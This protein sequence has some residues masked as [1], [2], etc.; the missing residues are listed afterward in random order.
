MRHRSWEVVEVVH[1]CVCVLDGGGGGGW[2]LQIHVL[3][4]IHRLC[5]LAFKFLYHDTLVLFLP[6]NQTQHRV[7]LVSFGCKVLVVSD[8]SVASC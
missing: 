7:S 1:N 4:F 3:C 6:C 2:W 5:F 8:A